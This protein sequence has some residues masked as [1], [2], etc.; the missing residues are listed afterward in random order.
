MS[1]ALR[2]L[3]EDACW[4][5]EKIFRQTGEI[6]PMWHYVKADGHEI[7][8]P[9]LSED[10]NRGVAMI[11]ALFALENAVRYVFI[12]EAWITVLANEKTLDEW[13]KSG[14]PVREHPK[15]REVVI[16]SGE[17]VD[18]AMM[19]VMREIIRPKIGKPRLGPP[20]WDNCKQHEG[21]FVGLLPRR[22]ATLQ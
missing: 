3:I 11:R 20:E 21:R 9:A 18:G 4:K 6:L 12:D 2:Q 13:L 7:I 8:T 17:D 15:R 19:M 16:I 22:G 14:R 10:K 5:I 1:A